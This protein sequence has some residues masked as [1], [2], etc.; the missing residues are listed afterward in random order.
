[1]YSLFSLFAY[2]YCNSQAEAQI[3]KQLAAIRVAEKQN[4]PSRASIKLKIGAAAGIA[5]PILA[6]VCILGAIA[7]SSSFSWT[8]NALSDLG[9]ISGVAG[10]LFNFGLYGSGFLGLIFATFGLY[11][12]LGKGVVGK[13]GALTFAA[14]TVALIAIGVFNESFSKIH[15]DVSVAFFVL[16][17]ISLLI[18]TFAFALTH[19]RLAALSTF[20]TGVIA[21]SPW[22]VL[23]AYRYVSN[24]A[25]PET[26]SA[27]A[28]S[29]WVVAVC[30]KI[31]AQ[32]KN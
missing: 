3:L 27:L 7:T 23:F 11:S 2:A 15:F 5:A 9:I 29:A 1:M 31:L 30:S 20:T 24:V 26:I 21:A 28:I 4:L 14:A 25:I 22:I 6:F 10:P 12:H 17:P 32:A 13:V 16:A 19:Q 18:I 8:N